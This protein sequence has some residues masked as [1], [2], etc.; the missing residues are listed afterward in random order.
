MAILKIDSSKVFKLLKRNS[1]H[2][3]HIEIDALIHAIKEVKKT[4]SREEWNNL[5][6]LDLFY[7]YETLRITAKFIYKIS[8]KLYFIW[9]K[10]LS[11]RMSREGLIGKNMRKFPTEGELK[12][13]IEYYT[14]RI[15]ESFS[16]V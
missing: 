4:Y 15:Y 16:I 1:I 12:E 2:V 10:D 9:M 13:R 8:D 11:K 14:K 3:S 5:K 6:F 7:A